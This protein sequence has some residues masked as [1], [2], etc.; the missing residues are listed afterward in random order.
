MILVVGDGPRDSAALPALVL[1]MLSNRVPFQ[2][3][4]WHNYTHLIG[5]GKGTIYSKKVKY[6]TR[7]AKDRDCLGLVVVTD[8][9]RGKHGEKL[10][11]LRKGRSEEREK[12]VPFPTALGEANPHFDVW[13]LDDSHAVA[14]TLSLPPNRIPN[15][16]NCS[17]PK[18]SLTKL[19]EEARLSAD[20]S[21]SLRKIAEVVEP[22]RCVHSK[23]T[24]FHE[25]TF[26]VRVEL[27][28]ELKNHPA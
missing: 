8:T 14:I 7:V 4:D 19:I 25:F 21:D 2:F 9:D 6:F 11:E 17:S 26:E 3:V 16:R 12:N 22:S 15:I 23:E 10:Q 5:R 27:V 24:G 13:L 1:R 28:P 18:D 20:L